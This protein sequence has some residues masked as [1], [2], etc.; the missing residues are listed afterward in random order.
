LR[1]AT[2]VELDVPVDVQA[3]EAAE[4][5]Y[6][7]AR[8]K[9][10]REAN[11]T[12]ATLKLGDGFPGNI[13]GD[14]T[15]HGPSW[16]TCFVDTKEA[17]RLTDHGVTAPR[18]VLEEWVMRGEQEQLASFRS[19]TAARG[20]EASV[21]C[22]PLSAKSTEDIECIAC[23]SSG[24]MPFT[25]EGR[26]TVTDNGPSILTFGGLNQCLSSTVGRG[27]CMKGSIAVPTL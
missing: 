4:E 3:T 2:S 11:A 12:N 8:A 14:P 22:V 15:K 21:R 5:A 1:A 19:W 16:A 26:I 7:A 13:E 25:P 9:R 17:G 10:A 20:G 24:G 23:A 27:F 6:E 18:N